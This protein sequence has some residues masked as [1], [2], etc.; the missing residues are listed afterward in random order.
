[1]DLAGQRDQLETQLAAERAARA[2]AEQ[3]AVAAQA[4]AADQARALEASAAELQRLRSQLTGIERCVAPRSMLHPLGIQALLSH[5]ERWCLLRSGGRAERKVLEQ[6]VLDAA[7]AAED[8]RQEQARLAQELA[9]AQ[10]ALAD[11]VPSVALAST[12]HG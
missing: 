6:Q 4:M 11:E 7:Q 3:A 1:M 5:A 10:R 12:R 2:D 8:A 9:T